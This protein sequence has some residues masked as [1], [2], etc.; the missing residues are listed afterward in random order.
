MF[1]EEASRK[2]SAFSKWLPKLVYFLV[3]FMI[4]WRI[5]S[6]WLGYFGEINKAINF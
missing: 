4:A 1:Q 3:V 6:F 2:L 5:I